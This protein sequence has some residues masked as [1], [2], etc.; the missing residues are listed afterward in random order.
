[1]D[2]RFWIHGEKSNRTIAQPNWN[3][4]QGPIAK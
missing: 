3:S 2:G 4:D 1:M